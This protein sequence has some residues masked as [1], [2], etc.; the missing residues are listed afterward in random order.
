MD[1]PYQFAARSRWPR[2]RIQG[3]GRYALV[4]TCYSQAEFVRLYTTMLEAAT[5]LREPCGAA[6]GCWGQHRIIELQP[7]YGSVSSFRMP[8]DGRD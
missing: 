4:A 5:D 8:G 3:D 7:D 2:A 1:S 6:G